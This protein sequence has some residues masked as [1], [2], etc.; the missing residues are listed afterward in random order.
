MNRGDNRDEKIS[1]NRTH[2]AR[3]VFAAAESM[4]ISDR[5]L[6]E[7]LTAQVIKRLEKSKPLP[8]TDQ[9]RQQDAGCSRF[10]FAKR[11]Q[12]GFISTH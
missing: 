6:V 11:V 3:A 10:R 2:I 12:R 1:L 8:E 5:P 9:V 4:G 7:Q